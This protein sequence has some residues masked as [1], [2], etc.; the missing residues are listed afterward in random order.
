MR[1]QK[2]WMAIASLL[3][4]SGCFEK[5]PDYAGDTDM[6]DTGTADGADASTS[7][8]SSTDGGTMDATSGGDGDT[9][10]G[11]WTDTSWTAG[12]DGDGDGDTS[13]GGD[14]DGDG[15]A[16]EPG[17]DLCAG[18]CVNLQMNEQHCGMCD[19]PCP[20]GGNQCVDGQCSG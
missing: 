12:G 10:D 11:G 3:L 16:C 18:E 7:S 19:H 17:L 4:V 14:G 8:T 2:P 9:T 6:G 5:N 20:G 1:R 13:T 15:D